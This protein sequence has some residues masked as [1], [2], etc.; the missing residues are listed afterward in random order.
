V[1]DK[2]D[3]PDF[4]MVFK[5]RQPEGSLSSKNSKQAEH[6]LAV[7]ESL[8]PK[9]IDNEREVSRFSKEKSTSQLP[10]RSNFDVSSRRDDKNNTIAERLME[11]VLEVE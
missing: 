10:H 11:R 3:N 5:E 6:Y 9:S 8:A 7:L 4:R 2:S 1:I